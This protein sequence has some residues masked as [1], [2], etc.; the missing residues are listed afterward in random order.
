MT[1]QRLAHDMRKDQILNAALQLAKERGFTSLTRDG[2]AI[3]AGCAAG[4]IN[5]IYSTIRQ[6]RKAVMRH[7]VN[8]LRDGD[9]NPQLLAIVAHG[10]AA[11][12]TE[13]QKAPDDIKKAA[14]ASLI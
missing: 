14:L 5:Q 12:E 13:A 10:L 4:Q 7:A 8:C 2:I 3:Q 6:L 9:L 1:R 11:G